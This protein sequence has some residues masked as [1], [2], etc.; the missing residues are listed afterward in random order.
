MELTDQS[1]IALAQQGGIPPLVEMLS[2]GKMEAKV[3]GLGAL[4]NLSTPPANREILLNWSDIP[5]S[6]ALIFRNLRYSKFEGKCSC[7][8]CESSYGN[9]SRAGHVR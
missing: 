5:S 1:R 4:K 6:A 7:H 3:A 8:T 2:V 9:N